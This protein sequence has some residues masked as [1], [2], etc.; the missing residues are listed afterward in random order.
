MYTIKPAAAI[1]VT[2]LIVAC[3]SSK[4]M[5]TPAF[6]TTAITTFDKQGH[7]GCR[8][9]MP[10]NTVPAMLKALD[11]GVTTL[12]MDVSI[13]QDNRVFLSH[14]PFFNHEITTRPDG[15]FIDVKD[16]QQYNMYHMPYDSI[17][18]YDV[19]KKPHPRFAQQ[20]KIAAVKPLLSD[21]FDSVQQYMKIAK[22]TYPFFNIETKCMPAT[23]NTYHPGPAEFVELLMK[24]IKDKGMEKQVIIQSFD[25]RSLQYLHL[26]YPAIAT[27]MLIEDYDKRTIQEQIKA[28]GFTPTC[29]SPE[30]SLVTKGLIDFCHGQHIKIIP[31]TVNDINTITTLKA[32]GV[33]GVISDY[34]DL[35]N[36]L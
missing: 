5:S 21:L 9:L 10:E 33:D 24:V 28:L 19:G 27:A 17:K 7:R 34:P 18:Q 15:S 29:Y 22:R 35:F 32:L 23:D 36:Q 26:H 2:I 11:L 8:G 25:F 14:E 16:E 1:F 13:S 30:H 20:Q 4:K 31:W 12:E 3:S 6:S